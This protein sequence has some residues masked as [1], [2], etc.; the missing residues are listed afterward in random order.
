[1]EQLVALEAA[2]QSSRPTIHHGAKAPNIQ[3]LNFGSLQND[4]LSPAARACSGVKGKARLIHT[5][6][7]T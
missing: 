3:A 5:E 7:R 2:P 4:Q 1:M 6:G